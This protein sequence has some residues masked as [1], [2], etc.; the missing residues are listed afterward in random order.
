[1]TSTLDNMLMKRRWEE[2]SSVVVYQEKNYLLQLNY[3]LPIQV[4][5]KLKLVLKTHIVPL[6]K[7]ANPQRMRENLDVF[8]FLLTEE[9]MEEIATLD[10]G[11]TCGI[12][13][14]TGHAV[15]D[16]L[17]KSLLYQV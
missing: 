15:T 6:V 17:E 11:H 2:Q 7:S 9:E 4:T 12:A 16:F 1:M 13:R 8:D 5:K 3:G 10:T 14:N